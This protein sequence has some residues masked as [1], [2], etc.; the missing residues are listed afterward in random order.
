MLCCC[1]ASWAGCGAR[2]DVAA[3]DADRA[4]SHHVYYIP[5]SVVAVAFV[6]FTLRSHQSLIRRHHHSPRRPFPRLIRVLLRADCVAPVSLSASRRHNSSG[7]SL[8]VHSA[9][10]FNISDPCT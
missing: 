4:S 3:T 10:S 2:M 6:T 7:V 1:V 9:L 8:P 5:H